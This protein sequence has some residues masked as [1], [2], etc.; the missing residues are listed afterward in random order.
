[1]LASLADSMIVMSHAEFRLSQFLLLQ[2]RGTLYEPVQEYKDSSGV[3]K[4]KKSDLVF[5]LLGSQ[6]SNL[7]CHLRRIWKR[8]IGTMKLKN[9]YDR[10]SL[11]ASF[12]RKRVQEFFD[13]CDSIRFDVEV[14]RPVHLYMVYH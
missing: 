1:M 5:A 9:L 7:S 13:G 4:V 8:Q 6:F 10:Q 12:S 3:R 11:S 14:N 2:F